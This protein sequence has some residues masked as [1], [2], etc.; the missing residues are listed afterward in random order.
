[1]PHKSLTRLKAK[2]IDLGSNPTLHFFELAGN[3]AKLHNKDVSSIGDIPEKTGMS[4]RRVYYLL[5]V[6]RLIAASGMSKA[7]AE[8]VGWTKLQIIAR[9]LKLTGPC[10][11]GDLN[12]FLE[13]ARSHRARNLAK[14]LTGEG[15]QATRIVSFELTPTATSDLNLALVAHGAK[16]TPR[17]LTGKAAAL[18]KMVKSAMSKLA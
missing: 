12:D 6:G 10:E 14:A 11:A 4:R 5:D 16:L 18:A 17:G 7:Q 2:I 8:E 3:L 1:M 13:L 9:H 15:A